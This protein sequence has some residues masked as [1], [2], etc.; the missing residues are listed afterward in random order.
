MEK[1]KKMCFR[2]FE[3]T[4]CLITAVGS[5][6]DKIEPESMP[7]YIVPAPFDVENTITISE[8]PLHEG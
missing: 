7:G 1:Y 3:K 2:S 4:G 8:S 6:D 5:Y